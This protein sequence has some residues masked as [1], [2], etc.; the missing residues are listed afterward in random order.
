MN[1]GNC[2]K[3]EKSITTSSRSAHRIP[4]EKLDIGYQHIQM[5][6]ISIKIHSNVNLK[7]NNTLALKAEQL[8]RL[9]QHQLGP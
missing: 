1:Y 2:W 3:K 9:W 6:F 8:I 5:L 7:E 4:G